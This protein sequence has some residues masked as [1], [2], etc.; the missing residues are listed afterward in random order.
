[1]SPGAAAPLR[2]RPAPSRSLGIGL[3]LVHALAAVATALV[4]AP[5]WVKAAVTLAL[6]VSLAHAFRGHVLRR[7]PDAV[8]EAS[9]DEQGV[10]RLRLGCGAEETARLL[11]DSLVTVPLVVLNFATGRWRR[12]SLVL[13]ADALPPEARRR[14]RVR[15]RLAGA[16]GPR[17]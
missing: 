16:E 7:A 1:V 12:R 6:A 4:P 2:L 5:G 11:P 17:R 15:L 3:A 13:P 8:V 9:W 14:L 10:W